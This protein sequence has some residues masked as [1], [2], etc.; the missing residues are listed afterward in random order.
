MSASSDGS[1]RTLVLRIRDSSQVATAR[2]EATALASALGFDEGAAGKVAI[3]V[4]ELA[5]NLL[6]H[7]GG[8][9]VVVRAVHAS[10]KAGVEVLGLDRG[11]GIPNVARALEDGF[12]TAGSP[13]TGLGAVRRLAQVFEVHTA[14]SSGTALFARI[15]PGAPPAAND[16][17]SLDVA[18]VAVPAPGEG[19]CGDAWSVHHRDGVTTLVMA[20]G[21]GHGIFAADA[22]SAAVRVFHAHAMATPVRL[23]EAIHDGLRGTRGAA[24]A[25]AQVEPAR[26]CVRYAGIGNI[27]GVV[28]TPAGARHMVSHNGI[29]GH[30]VRRI[31]EF[32][33]P[34]SSDAL[35]VLHSDGLTTHWRLDAYPGLAV[36]H[37]A[38]VAGVLYRDFTRGRDDVSVVVGREV[39]A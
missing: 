38:L 9:E 39:P 23:L 37:P 20:D 17:R 11:R 33:Y 6:K 30:S 16:G 10:D 14:E 18:G 22:A 12:S 28:L 3:V 4:T 29:V 8:G 27:A 31:D 1:D 34:W 24:V 5:T 7:A 19:V 32:T 21:L 2:R 25:V 35:L 13:G 26:G 36:R 15:W